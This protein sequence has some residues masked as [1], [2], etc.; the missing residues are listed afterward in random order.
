LLIFIAESQLTFNSYSEKGKIEMEKLTNQ[1]AFDKVKAHLATMK[2]PCKNQ[3]GACVY[4]DGKGNQCAV[5]A[6]MPPD[7]RGVSDQAIDD[8]LDDDGLAW[9]E[10]RHFFEGVSDS[11][12]CD[13][14]D[15]HDR[16]EHWG[17]RGF[18]M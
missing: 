18:E 5:G 3:Y 9:A 16:A 2:E 12:L 8:I 17:V 1:T 6:L 10:I 4:D 14:Q 11:L 15:A 7:L 13:L